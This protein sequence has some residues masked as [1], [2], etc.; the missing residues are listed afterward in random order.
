MLLEQL[1]KLSAQLDLAPSMYSRTPIRWV[2]PLD[3]K[4]RLIGSSL[5]ETAGKSARGK[6]MLAPHVQRTVAVKAKLLADNGEYILGIPRDPVKSERVARCHE[7]FTELVARCAEET[8]EPAVIAVHRFL[9]RLDLKDLSLPEN[10]DPADNLTFRVGETFPI[11]LTSVQNW[12]AKTTGEAGGGG[13]IEEMECLVCGERK[14][15]EKRLPFKIKGIPGGQASGTALVSANADAFESYG[16]EAS[17]ISPICR[18]CGEAFAKAANRLMQEDD[19]HLRVGPTVYLFWTRDGGEVAVA[20]FLRSPRGEEVKALIASVFSGKEESTDLDPE[21]FYAVALTASGGRVVVRDWIDTTVPEVKRHLARF[22]KLQRLIDPDAIEAPRP[23]GVFELGRSTVRQAKDLRAEVVR[24]LLSFALAG[25]RLPDGLLYEAVRRNRADRRIPR[26]RAALIKL[27]LASKDAK[28]EETMT[29][30]D[31]ANRDPA[32]L[33]GRLFAV[34]EDVQREAIPGA[35]ATMVDRFFG[36]ASAAPA[37]V[38]GVL[39]RHA[40]AHLAKLRKEK[41]AAH[42]ALQRRLE[43]VAKPLKDYPRTLNMRQQARFALG[44][45]HQRADRR[46]GIAAALEAKRA[47]ESAAD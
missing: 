8:E 34:L 19:K 24:P 27:I 22:F 21:P 25:G 5:E 16:L 30:L 26:S 47:A 9:A 40:Q 45:Y 37:S 28:L 4:G 12:W 7:A 35:R 32:Y 15:V 31:Q 2:I 13:E 3:E 43:D 14:Q 46:A 29:D 18:D 42:E 1:R 38:F 41:P 44:Y 17:L 36:S 23:Y 20:D 6:R 39:M 10:F 33:C 11:G